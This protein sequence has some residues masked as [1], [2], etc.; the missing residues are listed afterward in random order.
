MTRS[1]KK[2]NRG[3]KKQDTRSTEIRNKME[4]KKDIFIKSNNLL[5]LHETRQKAP[6]ARTEQ[7]FPDRRIFPLRDSIYVGPL[8]GRDKGEQLGHWAWTTPLDNTKFSVQPT[9]RHVRACVLTI[10]DGRTSR[11]ERV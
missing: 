9:A 10:S 6:S 7:R 4:Q 11:N 8:R 3:G 1:I 2:R 5:L